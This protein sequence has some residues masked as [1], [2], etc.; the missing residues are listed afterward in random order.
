M[1]NSDKIIPYVLNIND[2]E[3]AIALMK[4][5]DVGVLTLPNRQASYKV[6]RLAIEAGL[7]IVDTIEEFNFT[8]DAYETEGLKVRHE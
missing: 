2:K 6:I 1:K 8:P 3:S 5:C 7:N 4:Q